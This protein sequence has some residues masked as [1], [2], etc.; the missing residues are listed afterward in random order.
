MGQRKLEGW[1]TIALSG[2]LLLGVAGCWRAVQSSA[3]A[4]SSRVPRQSPVPIN[5]RLMVQSQMVQGPNFV[6]PK[7]VS[8]NIHFGLK[9]FSE[10]QKRDRSKNIFI[11]PASIAIAL[12]MAYNGANGETQQAMARAMGVQGMGL[13][14]FNQANAELKDLLQ[15]PDPQVQLAIANSLWSRQGIPFKPEFLQ[16]NRQFYQAKVSELDFNNPSSVATINNWVSQSTRGKIDTIVDS[17]APEDVMLLINAIYF[18]GNWT[19]PF[20][21]KAT[22]QN[23]FHLLNNRQK[24]HPMMTQQGEYRYYENGQF[25]AVSL[26]YGANQRM[27][28]IILLPRPSVGL[29]DLSQTL[30][31]ENSLTWM[32]ELRS[33]PGSIQIPRFKLEYNTELTQAL[34]A[35]GMAEA[36]SGRANFSGLSQVPTKIDQVKHKTFVEVN[37]EGTE[38]AAVTSIGIRATSAIM[39]QEPFKLV[40]DRPFLCAIRDNNTG[41]ILFLGAIVDPNL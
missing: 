1:G 19:R 9:L 3:L 16:R 21:P 18:K 25:Q 8:A 37:E 20:D 26:P 33:R 6:N 30:T 17:L 40:V 4:N 15:N 2:L 10:I 24:Q 14:E 38:A 11:S 23:T 36:F 35:L 31:S 12:A 34:S 13:P 32:N 41:S 5:P 27:S 7:L 39:P 29:S 28:M 22:V